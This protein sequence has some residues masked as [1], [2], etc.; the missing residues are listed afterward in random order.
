MKNIEPLVN[1]ESVNN[2]IEI[3][4]DS[5][6]QSETQKPKNKKKIV[7]ISLITVVL[8]AT[9]GI[10]YSVLKDR[11]TELYSSQIND[12]E[13]VVSSVPADSENK[14]EEDDNN[15]QAVLDKYQ[16]M[17]KNS[18]SL[19]EKP[20]KSEEQNS[21]WNLISNSSKLQDTVHE[22]GSNFIPFVVQ[23]SESKYYINLSGFDIDTVDI[24]KGV[25]RSDLVNKIEN[26]IKNLGYK[27][28]NIGDTTNLYKIVDTY[29]NNGRDIFV[30]DDQAFLV[31]YQDGD[32][33][34]ID[35]GGCYLRVTYSSNIEK[36]ISSQITVLN[37]L[38]NTGSSLFFDKDA[39]S[40]LVNKGYIEDFG[41]QL[42]EN[43]IYFSV[44]KYNSDAS[45]GL[46]KMNS[47][48]KYGLVL[49]FDLEMPNSTE[50]GN[51]P[52]NILCWYMLPQKMPNKSDSGYQMVLQE[53]NFCK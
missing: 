48:G 41:K 28:V 4:Q 38:V 24:Q 5:P 25:D 9:I 23:S 22:D 18:P 29:E 10:T 3:N 32:C 12:E 53:I 33:E 47:N 37:K 50:F 8:L 46:F 20:I 36:Q 52:K 45:S 27:K 26:Y 39:L 6:V 49:S 31:Y 43:Y 2:P 16:N 42:D 7:F 15:L 19:F 34:K 17:Y 51:Y 21:V 40:S 13:N 11:S 35:Y 14:N 30:K 1:Q 44:G